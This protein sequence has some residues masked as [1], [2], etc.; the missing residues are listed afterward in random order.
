MGNAYTKNGNLI[1]ALTAYQR[2]TVL[3]PN[4][5]T[6][7]RLLAVFCAENGVHLEG[8]GFPSCEKSSGDC[9]R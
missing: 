5:S 1:A 8:V 6:Y 4:K 7:W 3:A 2:A 9:T